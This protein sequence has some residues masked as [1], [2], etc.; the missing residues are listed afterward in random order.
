MP[1]SFSIQA[2]NG[3]WARRWGIVES[4][5]EL[6][7]RNMASVLQKAGVEFPEEKRRRGFERP[8]LLLC[9]F[10]AEER[11][12]GYLE[13]CR[14][15]D[16]PRAI[17]FSSLQIVPEL[18]GSSLFGQL[19]AVL[20]SQLH[21]LDFDSLTSGVQK[22]NTAA[23]EIYRRLG[24]QLEE[25][26]PPRGSWRVTGSRDLLATP[27]AKRLVARL[28][29]SEQTMQPFVPRARRRLPPWTKFPVLDW[30]GIAAKSDRS[31][32]RAQEA[33]RILAVFSEQ[34]RPSRSE[35]LDD[36]GD[37]LPPG[38]QNL[39]DDEHEA[40]WDALYKVIGFWPSIRR[41]DWPGFGEPADSVTWSIGHVYASHSRQLRLGF[42]LTSAVHDALR[43]IVPE[44]S[45]VYALNWQHSCYRFSPHADFVYFHEDDWPIPVFPG[46]DYYLFLDPRLRW[47]LL[48][49]PWEQTMCA[50]GTPL[51]D[52]LRK[53]PCEALAH[54][55]RAMGRRC[56]S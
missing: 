2:M 21:V 35:Q 42:E 25:H 49:H 17:Y 23:C 53:R 29:S 52:A 38:W 46:G 43:E 12:L 9:A 37:P 11:L 16:D 7:R 54:P 34:L 24:L 33:G 55:I 39:E 15:W 30:Q 56:R 48:G 22:N 3:G 40:A 44:D 27:F 10:D 50:F 47:G 36:F 41:G 20:L 18:R 5:I 31:V 45:F 4:I 26:D 8:L 19:L 1:P 28:R 51:I 6:D 14:D 32:D 13:I